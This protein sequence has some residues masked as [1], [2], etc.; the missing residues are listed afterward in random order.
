MGSE[1]R[2]PCD[3]TRRRRFSCSASRVNI[4]IESLP[5]LS[6]VS[7]DQDRAA[8]SVVPVPPVYIVDVPA[9]QESGASV[10]RGKPFIVGRG[11]D[12][13]TVSLATLMQSRQHACPSPELC[14]V[15]AVCC[16][17]CGLT[18][19]RCHV[20]PPI[21]KTER[22]AKRYTLSSTIEEDPTGAKQHSVAAHQAVPE[23]RLPGAWIACMILAAT[24]G[25]A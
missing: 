13:V 16:L 6:T 20:A 2:R 5:P 15:L 11:V 9:W 10:D 18:R 8:R 22:R 1:T 21:D 12:H 23:R 3:R 17:E 24:G 14:A 4:W 19:V 7:L 25:D